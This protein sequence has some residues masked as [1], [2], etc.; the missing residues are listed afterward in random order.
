MPLCYLAFLNIDIFNI[1]LFCPSCHFSSFK[2]MVILSELN[3]SVSLSS[4]LN[5]YLSIFLSILLDSFSLSLS[6][7]FFVFLSLPSLLIFLCIIFTLYFSLLLLCPLYPSLHLSISLYICLYICLSVCLSIYQSFICPS[8]LCYQLL[9]FSLSST[10]SLSTFLSL[11]SPSL[12]YLFGSFRRV[13]DK[14]VNFENLVQGTLQIYPISESFSPFQT[15]THL[16]FLFCSFLKKGAS[17]WLDI[18]RSNKQI[19]DERKELK[20]CRPGTEFCLSF[21]TGPGISPTQGLQKYFPAI[22]LL[23]L[24]VQYLMLLES[25]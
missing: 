19:R 2:G 10:L 21:E 6:L 16:N 12:Q 3:P 7:S 1:V 25:R 9:F 23:S 4:F 8:L 17:H 20:S 24:N 5:K 11:L 18:S 14:L 22:L 15:A 13:Q